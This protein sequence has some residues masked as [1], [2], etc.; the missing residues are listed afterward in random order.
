M[1]RREV[2]TQDPERLAENTYRIVISRSYCDRESVRLF[3]EQVLVDHQIIRER[4]VQALL[5][6][7]V[8]AMKSLISSPNGPAATGGNWFGINHPPGV[9]NA[10]KSD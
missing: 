9:E 5:Y 1:F 4:Y 8:P 10:L 2:A 6:S 3:G 7:A